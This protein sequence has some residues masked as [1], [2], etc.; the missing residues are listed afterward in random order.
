MTGGKTDKSGMDPE[1]PGVFALFVIFCVPPVRGA[2]RGGGR[3]ARTWCTIP[4]KTLF[5]RFLCTKSERLFGV[6]PARIWCTIPRKTLFLR[7]LCTKF[8]CLF[9]DRPTQ[10]WCTIPC[11][12]CSS[13][14]FAPSP[15]PFLAN[16]RRVAGLPASGPIIISPRGKELTTN[17]LSLPLRR[18][19]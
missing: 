1:A 17:A 18:Q 7:F 14:S 10:A 4:R 3:P 5:L 16:G 11:K 13:V 6:P 12:P 8:G 15:G 2:L 9:G 19:F